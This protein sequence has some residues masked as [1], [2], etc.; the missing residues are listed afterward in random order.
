MTG[1]VYSKTL[2]KYDIS[3]AIPDSADRERI[4]DIIFTQL[5]YG[6]FPEESRH[7]FN[8]VIQKLKDKGCD[9]VVLGCTEIPLLVKP[10]DCPLP[11]LD[12][13]RLLARAALRKAIS[14]G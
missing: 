7:Y 10:D 14:Q 2:K 4:D 11:T 6:N 12:S 5:V 8:L 1:P 3:Y 9:A 13:T